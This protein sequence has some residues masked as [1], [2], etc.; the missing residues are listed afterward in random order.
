MELIYPAYL[1][2][3]KEAAKMA[4]EMETYHQEKYTSKEI[5]GAKYTTA[6]NFSM[7]P[8]KTPPT[9]GSLMHCFNELYSILH[10]VPKVES[11]IPSIE[12]LKQVLE[13]SCQQTIRLVSLTRPL[14][15]ELDSKNFPSIT[16]VL[17]LASLPRSFFRASSMRYS[18]S[19]RASLSYVSRGQ[20]AGNE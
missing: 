17:S 2:E 10:H 3:Q 5:L 15:S 19:E 6:P 20:V 9:P 14:D 7:A 13:S 16:C 8:L 18:R 12:R 11:L 1:K 4:T